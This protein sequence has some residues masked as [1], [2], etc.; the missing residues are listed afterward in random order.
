MERLGKG[1]VRT[2]STATKVCGLLLS[3]SERSELIIPAEY[4]FPMDE[5]ELDRIDA[6]HA[7]YFALLDGKHFFSPVDKPQRILDLGC[8]TGN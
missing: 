7:K 2:P 3:K 4:G 1:G 8:G 5:V 6:C